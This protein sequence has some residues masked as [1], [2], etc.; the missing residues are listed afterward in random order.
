[1]NFATWSIR[2]P[3][4]PIAVFLVLL[5]VGLYSF[6]RLAV[7]AMPNIDLPLVSVTVQQPGAAP[8]ELTRQVIQPI[9]DSI[10]SIT[11][12]R[13]IS[14]T[15]T[16]SSAVLTIEFELETDTDRAVNDVK[17]AVANV[18]ADL[19]ES[20]IEPLIRR[21]DVSGMA[22]LTYAVTDPTKSM[23]ELSKFVDDVVAR[24]LTTVKGVASISRIGGAD[25]QINVELDPDRIQAFGLTAAEVSDQLRSKNIDIGGGRGDLAGMEYSIRALGSAADVARLAATPIVIA[26]GRTI[27][28][29]QLGT[30]TDGPSDERKFALL[31]GKPVVAFGVFR[32]SGE[33]D[34]E[35]GD[36]TKARIAQIAERNPGVSIDLIDDATTHTSASYHRAMDT[37]Y[38]GAA[39]AVVVVFLFL[40]NWR[41]TL[42]AAVALPLSII[43][44]FFVMYML[45]FTLNGISLLAITLVTGILVDDA[46]VEIE[47][48][49]R[50]INM[51]VPA[52]QAS[53]EA[54]NEIGLTV[55]AISFSIVAVFAPVSFMGGIPGQ[56]FKQFGLTV[57]VSVLFS[58]LVARLITPMLA[59][60]FMRDNQHFS[61]GRDGPLL[62]LLMAILA[63]TLRHR[64]LTLLMGMGVFAG[65]IYSA[66]LLPTEFVPAQDVGRS[67]ISIELPPGSTISDTES[68]AR[69]VSERIADEPEVRT[70]FVN[71]GDGLVTDARVLVNYGS[72]SERERSSFE[73]EEALREDLAQ[74]PDI[75]LNFLSESGTSDFEIS[76]LGD[77]EESAAEAAERL[78]AAM[79]SLPTMEGV[80]SS[81]ALRRP[82]IQI[83]PRHEEAAQMGVTTSALAATLRIAT[84]GDTDSNLAKFNTGE[85][86][87]PIMVRLNEQAR[88]DLMTVRNLRVP[89]R[90]GQVP[91]EA[92]ADVTLSAGATEISRYDRRYRTTVSANLAQGALLGPVNQ[93]VSELQGTVDLPPGTQIQPAGDAEIMAEVFQA[94]AVAMVSG[95]ML[96]YVV[97]VL[98]FH[99][100]MTPVSILM[101]LPLAIGGAILALFLTGNSISMAV[102]IGFLMLMGIVTKNAIML[103]EFALTSIDRGVAKRD[104]ILDAVHKRAR[105]IVMTTIAMTAGMVPSALGTGEGAEFSSPM[106]IAVIGGLLLST[107]LSLLFVPSLFSMV[108]GAQVRGAGWLGRR[109]GLNK[110]PAEPAQT[111]H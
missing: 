66:T 13:H 51:G 92:V 28:L 106:A 95:V 62:R 85:E 96:T 94:F 40:R 22:I 8:S 48:I 59:A 16:D 21:I 23:E 63:W 84:L 83:E 1:M 2:R 47:N 78:M 36:G 15:A 81:A 49:V 61:E 82:E 7:T 12:V 41:A 43:P 20:I 34:L 38:E 39:L 99:N 71:G 26:Q 108:H 60:Y 76:V 89:G 93:Q 19:P 80:T 97:L 30:V 77:T 33:S 69:R 56:Y 11:G 101:S 74:I 107:L 103:V 110:P 25:R 70:V 14:S 111:G 50:H 65:S 35:A 57:A 5:L 31:D 17:D 86:Q 46:I 79:K 4:P 64:A 37:L 53:M 98:L 100:F 88:H 45:G 6:S 75:R 90:A 68:V 73:I 109:I 58:L 55:I 52:Y 24:E 27:R 91:L 54:A 72:K 9:E 67:Q 29:D 42:V 10:A 3:V 104:A 105:P 32:A 44:T 18:R 87:I 102:V